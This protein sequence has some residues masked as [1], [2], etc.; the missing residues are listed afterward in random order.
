M[1]FRRW[2]VI[3]L[4]SLCLMALLAAAYLGWHVATVRLQADPQ[5][6]DRLRGEVARLGTE[7][8]TAVG[9]LE[10]LRTR[11]QVDRRALE[12]LRRDLAAKREEVAG[13]EEELRFYRSLMAPEAVAGGLSIR[14]P[15]LVASDTPGV[16]A[17]RI[18]VQQE[19]RRHELVRGELDIEITG[20]RGGE[21]VRYPLQDVVQES[22]PDPLVLGFRYFQ[23]V[24]ARL[25]LPDGLQP[26]SITVQARF[27]EPD[28][29][30]LRRRFDWQVRE[31]F[32]HAGK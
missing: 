16:Y 29:L 4:V 30:Q 22:M 27:T 18:V 14:Q 8:E 13:L 7:L 28:A 26:S 6:A 21:G 15:E 10:V 12:M 31:R 2:F 19:A 3:A 25:R 9:E 11:N 5:S 23:A 20:S 24:E 32:T 17:L 1:I